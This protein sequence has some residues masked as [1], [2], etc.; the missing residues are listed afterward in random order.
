VSFAVN[1]AD[2]IT[3]QRKQPVIYACCLRPCLTGQT[4]D[5]ESRRIDGIGVLVAED[6]DAERMAAIREV[7]RLNGFRAHEFRCY[8]GR[9]KTWRRLK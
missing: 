8:E 3:L 4:V 6:V 7:L 2:V 9:R 5:T 1:L